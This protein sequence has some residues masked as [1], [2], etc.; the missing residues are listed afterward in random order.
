[1]R[2]QTPSAPRRTIDSLAPIV[3]VPATALRHIL[4]I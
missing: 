1:M 4:V 3:G 2:S